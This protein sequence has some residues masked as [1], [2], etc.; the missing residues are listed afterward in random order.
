MGPVLSLSLLH[1]KR[2]PASI[3][4]VPPPGLVLAACFF[5]AFA[6]FTP[7]LLG[8]D[9]EHDGQTFPTREMESVP[10]LAWLRTPVDP[11]LL[12]LLR[13]RYETEG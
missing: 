3:C 4:I 7:A 2:Y 10:A 6:I 5:L 8:S 9:S 13:R 1:S 11:Q 12:I